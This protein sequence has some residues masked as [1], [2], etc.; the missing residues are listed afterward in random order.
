MDLSR[1]FAPNVDRCR[2][3]VRFRERRTVLVAEF[4]PD[5]VEGQLGGIVEI[6]IQA[7]MCRPMPVKVVNDGNKGIRLAGTPVPRLDVAEH[8]EAHVE[9][10]VH[11][12]PQGVVDLV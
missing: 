2:H 3:F 4:Q 1:L 9:A 12:T 11:G 6:Q 10:P 8:G 5:L 7:L